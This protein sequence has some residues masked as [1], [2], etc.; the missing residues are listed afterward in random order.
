M[1]QMGVERITRALISANKVGN[2]PKRSVQKMSSAASPEM[3]V[4]TI[5]QFSAVKDIGRTLH[6]ATHL[7]EIDDPVILAFK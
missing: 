2:L 4:I 1:D 5:V 6:V 7:T 3:L